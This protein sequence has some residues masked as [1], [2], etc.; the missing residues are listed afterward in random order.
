MNNADPSTSAYGPIMTGAVAQKTEDDLQALSLGLARVP[1]PKIS[2]MKDSKILDGDNYK[3]GIGA[4][5]KLRRF[6]L[7][8]EVAKHNTS[9][10]IWV[11]IFNQVFDLT[12]LIAENSASPLCDPIVLSAG[13]DISHW[14]EQETREPKTYIHPKTNQKE[15]LCPQGRYLHVPP[16]NGQS[17]HIEEVVKFDLPWWLDEE[18]YLIGRLTKKVRKINLVNTLTKDEQ[19][20][21][22]ASEENMNEILDR[23]LPYNLHAASY[24]WKRL[25]KVLD[26]N[27]SLAENGINDETAE[28]LALGINP[29]EYIPAVH[30]YFND[31]LTIA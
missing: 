8:S 31:D 11:S 29:D 5:Y 15:Y 6:Y 12:K 3:K 20:L 25:G 7:P 27:G 21:E 23:Y 30:L 4:C 9:N 1:T 13:Q 10:D 28:C 2:H 24:T 19:T 18:K 17:D 14:F 16:C 22:V 26:M